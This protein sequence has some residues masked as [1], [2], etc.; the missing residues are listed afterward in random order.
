[1][2]FPPLSAS[3]RAAAPAVAA[4]L[5]GRTPDVLL[6]DVTPALRPAVLDL[7]FTTL[8]DYGRGDFLLARLLEKPLK[9]KPARAL[10][11]IALARLERRPE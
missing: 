5:A 4:V 3:L 8:R 1:M 9:D 10:L 7:T 11:L 2:K 6:A